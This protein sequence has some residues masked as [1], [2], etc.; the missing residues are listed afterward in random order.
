MGLPQDLGRKARRRS[1][2]RT[3]SLLPTLS[4]SPMVMPKQQEMIT[5]PDLESLSESTSQQVESLLVVTLSHIYLRNLV[6][7]NSRKL[8]DLTISSISFFSHTEMEFV[9]VVC[10]QSAL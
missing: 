9:T 1:P 2:L 7:L 10:V 3:R 6:L 8:R 4:L 5:H